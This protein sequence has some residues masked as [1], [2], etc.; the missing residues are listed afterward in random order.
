MVFR[1][2]VLFGL[3][4]VADGLILLCSLAL[5]IVASNYGFRLS[6][7]TE[8]LS[9]Q[10][11]MRNA[12]FTILAIA[13]WHI[14][15]K[16]FSLYVTRRMGSKLQECLDIVKAT[17]VGTGIVSG[18]LVAGGQIV[19]T[20]ILVLWFWFFSTTFT[21][22]SRI[23]MRLFLIAVRNKG[24]NLRLVVI[25]GTNQKVLS[26]ARRLD[27]RKDIGYKIVGFVDNECIS[28]EIRSELLTDLNHFAEVLRRH[29][30]DEVIVGL[31]VKS[32]FNQISE[33]I[34][35]CEEQGIVVRFLTDMLFDRRLAKSRVDVFEEFPVLTLYTGPVDGRLLSVKR[36]IDFIFSAVALSLLFPVFVIVGIA[37]RLTSSGPV[38]FV[39]E[40]VGYN[41]RRFKLYKF[42]TMIKEAEKQQ[43][44]LEDHNEMSG[45]VFK[46]RDDP[47]ITG[48]GEILRRTSI[49]ELPQLLNVVRGDMSLVGP[50]P[51]PV[52]DYGRFDEEWQ[53]RRFSVKPG[54]TCLWQING[55][56]EI[57]FE[58]WMRLDMEYIDNWS[59]VLDFKILL[60]TIPAVLKGPGAM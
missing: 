29:V 18:L 4:Q 57:P 43:A 10:I 51:L 11:T 45:P 54:M 28:P 9:V 32:F 17:T 25:V 14:V 40:R 58:D 15:F 48:I 8:I 36:G 7:L 5:A 56:N 44:E 24:R 42:R 30:V 20:G 50:R 1:R 53:K 2:A 35:L 39:Q 41:K 6:A 38:L 37:I 59:L 52:R 46:I 19:L 26:F 22:I 12:L 3:Y 49:D 27:A 55:R 21:L 13:S 33:I 31:P 23:F 60:K 16:G 34:R 47:R